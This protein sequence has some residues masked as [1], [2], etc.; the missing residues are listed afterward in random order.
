MKPLPTHFIGTGDQGA[1]GDQPAFHFL[2][3]KRTGR[4]ILLQKTRGESGSLSYEVAIVQKV[5]QRTFPNGITT[6]QHESMPSSSKW[7]D[8]GWS[9]VELDQAKKK[10]RQLEENADSLEKVG[11]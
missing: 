9:Y 11:K 5:A 7:G 2:I 1:V 6:P 10:F 8:S 4:I 3:L